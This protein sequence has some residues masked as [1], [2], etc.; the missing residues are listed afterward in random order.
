MSIRKDQV[1]SE[2]YGQKEGWDNIN[3]TKGNS[4]VQGYL[5]AL[6]TRIGFLFY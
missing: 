5:C 1:R 6:E 2:M 3:A 4:P